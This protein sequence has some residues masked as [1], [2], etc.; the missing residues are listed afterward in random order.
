MQY[1]QRLA[2]PTT[3]PSYPLPVEGAAH[4]QI[5]AS[6]AWELEMRLPTIPAGHIIVPSLAL[7]DDGKSDA[8]WL[9][10]LHHEFEYPLQ[11]VPATAAA[12]ALP[13]GAKAA[14]RHIDCWHSEQTL[15]ST[16]CVF[17]VQGSA[18]PERYLATLSVRPV[19]IQTPQ[20]API[21]VL[22]DVPATLSQ[23]AADAAIRQ[24]ICSPTA[25]TMALSAYPTAPVWEDT[26]AACY[27]AATR[28]YGVWP[29]A[30]RWAAR[31]GVVAAV[32][33]FQDWQAPMACLSAGVPLVCSIDYDS[34]K[35]TNAPMARTGGHLVVLYGVE[36]NEVLVKDPAGADRSDVTRRYDRSEFG[37][38]WLSRRGAAYIFARQ[39]NAA[40]S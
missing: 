34:G 22:V 12:P 10:T 40:G 24:R 16:R 13:D 18:Q 29:L 7:L 21:D 19:E 28:A 9:A 38:A 32:E 36:G 25:L 31:H 15:E 20:L 14:S 6:G 8:G 39:Q 17:T 2:D 11:S 35:L 23:H 1:I 26:I 27:D 3:A 33:V 30:I 5:A 37:E 4:W